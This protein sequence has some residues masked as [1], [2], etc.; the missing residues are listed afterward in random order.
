MFAPICLC[1]LLAADAPPALFQ[2]N[3]VVQLRAAIDQHGPRTIALAPGTYELT[4]PLAL[5]G[6][7]QV[8][9]LG[10]GWN[11]ILRCGGA[12]VAI[13]LT[14][15]SFCLVRDLLVV[16]GAGARDGLVF[17]GQS[18]SNTVDY[19]RIAE[20]VESGL[21]FAGDADKPMS[22]NVVRDCH[23]I[24]N[25]GEQL[26]SDYNNDYMISGCQFGAHQRQPRAG[27]ALRHSSAGNYTGCYHW[28]NQNALL[29]GP[30]SNFNRLLGNRFEESLREALVIG[31]A[32]PSAGW[33][34]HSSL[35]IITGN[36]FHT[37]SKAELGKYDTILAYDAVDT[38]FTG[39]QVF[40]WDS[41]H[42]RHRAALNLARGCG[43][44]IVRDNILRHHTGPALLFDPNAG[45][46]VKDNLGG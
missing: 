40:S 9:L 16:G 42:Y 22:S 15:C 30:G 45:H 1:L 36:T 2:V 27:A 7:N 6:D 19:C 23:L 4:E 46:L 8:C 13:S 25:G 44:W 24:D 37:T 10:S 12:E 21:R 18:S 3:T 39:N 32:Q 11:T 5:R 17:R 33:S 43:T 14:D 20:F 29:L 35:N 28:G 26:A 34:G 38:T 31:S 41:E